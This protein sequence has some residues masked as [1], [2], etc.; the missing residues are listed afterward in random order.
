MP[1]PSCARR[2]SSSTTTTTFQLRACWDLFELSGCYHS[3]LPNAVVELV[4]PHSK[5]ERTVALS[6]IDVVASTG[7]GLVAMAEVVALMI[8][9]V[10]QRYSRD[11]YSET[12]RADYRGGKRFSAYQW[13]GLVLVAH[14][15]EVCQLAPGSGCRRLTWKPD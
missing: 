9:E 14:S 3:C 6:D 15:A 4:T 7:I 12:L 2:G 8:G 11:E 5:N 10:E 1:S 13:M